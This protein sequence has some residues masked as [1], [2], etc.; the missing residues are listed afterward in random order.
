LGPNMWSFLK[1][2]QINNNRYKGAIGSYL[3]LAINLNAD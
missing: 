2:R 3:S 1:L